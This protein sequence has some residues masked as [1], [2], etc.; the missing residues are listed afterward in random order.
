MSV[1][2]TGVCE[3]TADPSDSATRIDPLR[4]L[5]ER[6]PRPLRFLGVGGI[7]LFTDLLV[8]TALILHWPHPLAARVISLA[9]ATLVTWRLNR[10]LTFDRSG[11]MQTEEAMR[12][13]GV[14]AVA[15]GA[16]YA[17]FAALVLTIARPLPQ[18][19]L[20]AGAVVGAIVGYNGHRLFAFK[21]RAATPI[22]QAH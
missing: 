3:A 1:G 4:K 5:A 15:Q 19:A 21:P 16:S 20:I 7:G 10:A 14:T 18:A 2:N 8:F 9:C 13:L 6:L 17:V 12:Y 22:T 11:R